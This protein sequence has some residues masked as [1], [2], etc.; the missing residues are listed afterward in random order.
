MVTNNHGNHG[1]SGNQGYSANHGYLLQ[2]LL[3]KSLT[4][5]L[6]CE[7]KGPGLLLVKDFL[8]SFKL[9]GGE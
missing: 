5:S 4:K 6:Y 8:N 1:Y 3:G 2:E 9:K 7:D